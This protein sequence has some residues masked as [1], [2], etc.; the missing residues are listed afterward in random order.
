MSK[1]PGME[2]YYQ[3]LLSKNG[4]VYKKS[5]RRVARSFVTGFTKMLYGCMGATYAITEG[6][7]GVSRYF[8]PTNYVIYLDANAGDSGNGLVVGTGTNAVNVG[9][10]ALQTLIAHGA[11]AGQLQYSACTVALP[12]FTSTTAELTITRL[13][14]NASG[15]TITVEEIGI[16]IY[17]LWVSGEKYVCLARDLATVVI[18]NGSTL[19]LN[20]VMQTTL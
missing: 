11:S 2:L 4:E 8:D 10:Y 19:T 3:Y 1:D 6:T 7:D 5:R 15:N 9:D 17:M 14:T 12:D 20:Y 13:F 16:Y 18:A